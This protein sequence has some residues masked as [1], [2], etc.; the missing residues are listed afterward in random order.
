MSTTIDDR[1]WLVLLHSAPEHGG[2]LVAMARN[3]EDLQA[4]GHYAAHGFWKRLAESTGLPSARWRNFFSGNQ[5]ATPG[6]IEAA[7]K[8][9]PEYAFWLATGVTDAINGHVAPANVLTF[10]ERP[11]NQ[12][13]WPNFYFRKEIELNAMLF[14]RANID[15]SDPIKRRSAIVRMRAALGDPAEREVVDIAYALC[16]TD[17]Y[18]ELQKGS[19][20]REQDRTNAIARAKDSAS[21]SS[22]STDEADPF[23]LIDSRT[24][25]Q[26]K[27]DLFYKPSPSPKKKKSR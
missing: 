18:G 27:W 2:L 14:D 13:V 4:D 1:L 7:A 16:K 17:A 22:E 12:S 6:M 9:W 5:N 19:K 15:C 25:H 23:S 21:L 3:L 20:A 11:Y 26:S 24:A 8:L 10:P